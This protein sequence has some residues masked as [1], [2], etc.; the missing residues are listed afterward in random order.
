MSLWGSGNMRKFSWDCVIL[1]AKGP[2][3]ESERSEGAIRERGTQPMRLSERAQV[4]H[5]CLR[6]A[7]SGEVSSLPA[8][9]SKNVWRICLLNLFSLS[10]M[11]YAFFILA[12]SLFLNFRRALATTDTLSSPSHRHWNWLPRATQLHSRADSVSPL[13]FLRCLEAEHRTP[14]V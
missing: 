3:C 10:A 4:P 7:G 14:E 5:S 13:V 8:S 11:C 9:A 6:L 1:W 12:I 2:G